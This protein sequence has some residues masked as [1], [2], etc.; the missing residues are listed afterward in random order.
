MSKAAPR[1]AAYYVAST[2]GDL[3]P[4]QGIGDLAEDDTISPRPDG[5]QLL[6]IAD[7]HRLAVACWRYA[8]P[9]ELVVL[10]RAA[11]AL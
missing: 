8:P 10:L 7:S 3:R 1:P 2:R 4:G 9:P 6:C 5:Y 11:P